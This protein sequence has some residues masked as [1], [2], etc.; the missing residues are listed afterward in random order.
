M[1]RTLAL[2]GYSH[3]P[4]ISGLGHYFRGFLQENYEAVEQAVMNEANNYFGKQDAEDINKN[5]NNKEKQVE[6]PPWISSLFTPP[7]IVQK[8]STAKDYVGSHKTGWADLASDDANK[9][10]HLTGVFLCSEKVD[11]AYEQQARFNCVCVCA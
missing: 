4:E 7:S 8:K 5:Y 6:E 3:L 11:W 2:A 10:K 9:I 1:H